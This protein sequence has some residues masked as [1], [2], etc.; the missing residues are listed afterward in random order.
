MVLTVLLMTHNGSY[1]NGKASFVLLA[2]TMCWLHAM[3]RH[4]HTS[5]SVSS[6]GTFPDNK[7]HAKRPGTI[8]LSAGQAQQPNIFVVETLTLLHFFPVRKHAQNCPGQ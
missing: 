8:L 4:L 2:R 3:H 6:G 5:S 7:G 1:I